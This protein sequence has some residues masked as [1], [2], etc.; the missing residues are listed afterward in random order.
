MLKRNSTTKVII[1]ISASSLDHQD[2]IEAVRELHTSTKEIQWGNYKTK[3]FGWSDIGYH[4]FIPR[5]NPKIELGRDL[6]LMGAH[7]KNHN[8]ESIGIC[9]SG[10]SHPTDA[11]LN[12]LKICLD[13]LFAM[14]PDLNPSR[15]FG[16]RELNDKKD[17]PLF[18]VSNFILDSYSENEYSL[19]F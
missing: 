12:E 10:N 11:Q 19:L 13:S 4:F 14:Y 1:H 6:S 9:L 3:G 17:C 16:H 2:N 5:N 18:S 8:S 15:V 7:C